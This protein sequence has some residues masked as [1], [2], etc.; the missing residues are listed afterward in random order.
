MPLMLHILS[1]SRYRK[2]WVCRRD[3]QADEC[4]NSLPDAVEHARREAQRLADERAHAVTLR[5]WDKAPVDEIFRPQRRA[6]S[7]AARG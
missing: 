2:Q 5:I 1:L 3:G 4:F 7:R 6:I